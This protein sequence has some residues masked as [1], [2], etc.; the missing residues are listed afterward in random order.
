MAHR[1]VMVVGTAPTAEY[2]PMDT[3]RSA[4]RAEEAKPRTALEEEFAR[5]AEE[6]RS[7]D[8]RKPRPLHEQ[9]V[10]PLPV[11][12]PRHRGRAETHFAGLR[13]IL[14]PPVAASQSPCVGGTATSTSGSGSVAETPER[15]RR[16][17]ETAVGTYLLG[18]K[19]GE[20][21]YAR[22][23]KALDMATGKVVAV[24]RFN[25]GLDQG[26]LSNV[27][28][29]IQVLKNL[30]HKN[31]MKIFGVHEECDCLHILLEYCENGSLLGMLREFSKFPEHLAAV[32]VKQVLDAL[33]Y[34]HSHDVI[35]RDLKAANICLTKRGRLKLGD[36]GVA[37]VLEGARASFTIVGSPYWMAPEII[38]ELGHN[39]L[40][41]IWSLG[42]TVIELITGHPPY[43]DC[44]NLRA[45]FKIVQSDIPI[46]DGISDELRDFLQL[47]LRKNPSGRPT[48]VQLL[49]HAW[50]RSNNCAPS[51]LVDQQQQSPGNTL[52]DELKQLR[53]SRMELPSFDIENIK[54]VDDDAEEP[55]RSRANSES[56]DADADA[57]NK[58]R[59]RAC[60]QEEAAVDNTKKGRSRSCSAGE[61]KE[62]EKQNG[63]DGG[64]DAA[65][66]KK[67]KRPHRK[68]HDGRDQTH[69]KGTPERVGSKSV[70]NTPAATAAAVQSPSSEDDMAAAFCGGSTNTTSSSERST[71]EWFTKPGTESHQVSQKLVE[72]MQHASDQYDTASIVALKP[73]FLKLMKP[74]IM[75]SPLLHG[76][77]SLAFIGNFVWVGSTEGV[78]SLWHSD[79]GDFSSLLRLHTSRV[80]CILQIDKTE[81]W[82]SSEEGILC[83]VALKNMKAKKVAVHTAEHPRTTA[84]LAV[85][86]G[87][88]RRTRVWSIAAS[89]SA[90][91][92]T[93]V[94]TLLRGK[95][96]SRTTISMGVHCTTQVDT[97]VW[98]GC[99][100]E[101]VV[102][103]SK[104]CVIIRRCLHLPPGGGNVTSLLVVGEQVLASCGSTVHIFS[105]GADIALVSSVK[106]SSDPWKLCLFQNLVLAADSCGHILCLDPLHGMR[107]VGMLFLPGSTGTIRGRLR[108]SEGSA[109]S[110][111]NDLS[112][113]S[114]TGG[115]SASPVSA[116]R[117]LL[118]VA[119][120]GQKDTVPAVWAGS[121]DCI[122]V[123]RME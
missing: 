96:E 19:I 60:T 16:K 117:A 109:A 39:T 9:E 36:F 32:F 106:V 17:I 28:K 92:T 80:N 120:P 85:N 69:T 98:V 90:A 1:S 122:C 14:S 93:Q 13:E 95:V 87:V 94:A 48:A 67:Y 29:E 68:H 8:E 78:V 30:H 70:P 55:S 58:V 114:D 107:Q 116:F 71:A 40:S 42:C 79:T 77:L 51:Q 34:L 66:K 61:S 64:D 41:D 10:A 6:E 105:H 102:F 108:E 18:E 104:T 35:H 26:A 2:T 57:D 3:P 44:P 43:Y 45:M 27:V 49:E 82:C 22:V 15:E 84:L 89:G 53:F 72:L 119:R 63:A 112:S 33:V 47:C 76:V 5:A 4:R 91:P 113:T 100:D 59:N 24:K 81:V 12:T 99:V 74:N 86:R 20:G 97:N 103:S 56:G 110:G 31:I 83:I 118:V 111:L 101:V 62:G 123:W 50:L 54:G 46:P 52:G 73:S 25:A 121:N 23:Y 38:S 115:F 11:A 7:D 75:K 37:A 21:A 88:W 65:D